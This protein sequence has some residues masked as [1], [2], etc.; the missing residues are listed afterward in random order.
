M[1]TSCLDTNLTVGGN[2]RTGRQ[3]PW[4]I[5]IGVRSVKKGRDAVDSQQ[6]QYFSTKRDAHGE[7]YIQ[8]FDEVLILPVDADGSILF[9]REPA[10]AFDGA[11][12]LILPGGALDTNEKP[13][14]TANRELQEEVGLRAGRL[15]YLGELRPWPKYLTVR[16][17]LYLG[18]DLTAS[19]L[20][21]D[22]R[23]PIGVERVAWN[24]I[25]ALMIA[26]RLSDARAIA[27][28]YRA[29]LFLEAQSAG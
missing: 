13:E 10:P 11:P 17:H 27:A 1:L 22:E 3:Q 20:P 16:S 6:Q 8:S 19:R 26:G 21:G 14:Q 4:G 12:V 29:R 15:D 7:A 9:A 5:E 28:I 25:E 2:L 23:H 24:E 18:R